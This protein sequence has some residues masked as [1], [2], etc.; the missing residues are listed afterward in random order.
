MMQAA[1]LLAP[2]GV[3]GNLDPALLL[4]S[5]ER[6]LEETNRILDTMSAYPRF[7][8]NLG[9]GVLKDTPP[10]TVKAVIDAVHTRK[11]DGDT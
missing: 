10:D 11:I 7:V 6:A 5:P 8:F 3:Q 4:A 9:H 2:A 1:R